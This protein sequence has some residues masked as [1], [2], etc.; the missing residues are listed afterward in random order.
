MIAYISPLPDTRWQNTWPRR[1]SI[2][3]STG[4]IGRSA[5]EIV[6]LEPEK[7]LVTALAGAMNIALLA[8]Q[9]LEFRPPF[10]AVCQ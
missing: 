2:L 9:A 3:G 6:R 8:E 1:L 10:L 7:F 4:S 5:V